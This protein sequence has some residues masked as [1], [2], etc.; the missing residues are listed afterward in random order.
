MELVIHCLSFEIPTAIARGCVKKTLHS[1][2]L[3]ER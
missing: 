2:V 3:Y 1:V